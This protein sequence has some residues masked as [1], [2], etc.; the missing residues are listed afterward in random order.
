MSA[1]IVPKILCSMVLAGMLAACSALQKK[2]PYS[3]PVEGQSTPVQKPTPTSINV[4]LAPLFVSAERPIP[5]DWLRL[6]SPELGIQFRFPPLPGEIYYEYNNWPEREGDPTGILV[7]WQFTLGEYGKFTF[8]ACESVDMQVGRERT[9][10]DITSVF[11]DE[12]LQ[13]YIVTY[14]LQ[15]QA[16]IQPLR[17]VTRSDGLQGIIFTPRALFEADVVGT[18]A[19]LSLPEGYLPKIKVISFYFANQESLD[20]IEA[21]LKSVSFTK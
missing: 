1:K 15:R 5:E 7:E 21:V 17:I 3:T 6:D 4:Y 10:T 11:F 18:L 9:Y 14:P 12:T 20:E 13:K 19:V 2:A 8:A 16:E